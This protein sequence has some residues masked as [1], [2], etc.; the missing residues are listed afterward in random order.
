MW[1][2]QIA[3]EEACPQFSSSIQRLLAG[4]HASIAGRRDLSGRECPAVNFS[5]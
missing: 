4:P 3:A 5:G 1:E 2:R